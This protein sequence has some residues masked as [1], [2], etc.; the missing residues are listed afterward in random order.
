MNTARRPTPSYTSCE[1]N[2]ARIRRIKK[3]THSS[4]NTHAQ[5]RALKLLQQALTCIEK[6]YYATIEANPLVP[7]SQFAPAIETNAPITDPFFVPEFFSPSIFSLFFSIVRWLLYFLAVFAPYVL[8]VLHL[9]FY[10]ANKPLGQ[11]D[12]INSIPEP[13]GAVAWAFF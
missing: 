2:P 13:V 1:D 3:N 8:L 6:R 4:T 12:R 5:T 9:L 10:P 7:N 11:Q